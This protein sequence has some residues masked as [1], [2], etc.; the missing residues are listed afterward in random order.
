MDSQPLHV[1]FCENSATTKNK[2]G[3]ESCRKCSTKSGEGMK[4]PVD[5][6]EL[7]PKNGKFGSYFF[8]WSCGKNWNKYH[9]KRSNS[10]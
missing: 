9:V 3:V 6:S 10:L 1:F 7:E 5:N 2:E 4:C 8:C